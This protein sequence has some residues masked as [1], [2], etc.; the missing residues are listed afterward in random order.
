MVIS[1]EHKYLFVEVPQTACTAISR[2]LLE[3]YGGKRILKKHATYVDFL[4]QATPAERDYFAF[5]GVRNPLDIAVSLYFKL[6]HNHKNQFTDPRKA[7]NDGVVAFKRQYEFVQRT[8]ADFPTF[9][10]QFKTSVHNDY[11]LL[12]HRDLDFIIRFENLADDFAEALR[13]IGLTPLRPLP[14]INPTQGKGRDFWSY[15]T[16]EIRAQACRSF[17]PYLQKWGYAFPADW[18]QPRVPW[19]S[20]MRFR[21]AD[22]AAELAARRLGMS[23]NALGVL[24]P[25]RNLIRK[26]WA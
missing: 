14:Q 15:Y 19:L 4:K 26:V 2:E 6:K 23:P 11:Y 20:R 17:G 5:A 1:H 8:D 7:S 9:F 12:R 24:A 21:T 22:F 3:C 13:R 10:K 16:P 18:G 25:A